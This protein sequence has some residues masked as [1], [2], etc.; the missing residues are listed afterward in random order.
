M[1]TP[2]TTRVA[3]RYLSAEAAATS[4]FN[5]MRKTKVLGILNRLL[6][7]HTKGIFRDQYWMPIQ[8]I[9]KMFEHENIPAILESAG[10]GHDKGIPVRKVWTYT[11]DFINQNDRPDKVTIIITASGAG[12]VAE[13][14]D[15]YDVTAYAI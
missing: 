5:G 15:A 14:L 4:P 2:S 11:V 9:R 6:G 1:S 3:H 10:Y 12:S 7:P 8:N 13:P